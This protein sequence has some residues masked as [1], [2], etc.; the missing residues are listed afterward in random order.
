MDQ[1]D[2][3]DDDDNDDEKRGSEANKEA[4]LK[5]G[6]RTKPLEIKPT[7]LQIMEAILEKRKSDKEEARHQKLAASGVGQPKG[8]KISSTA[9]V[10][11]IFA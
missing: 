1:S 2:D 9:P 10:R 8:K 5:A 3:D 11:N 4:L 6:I 7:S